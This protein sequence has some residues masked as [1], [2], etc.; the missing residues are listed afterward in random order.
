MK[1]LVELVQ[2]ALDAFMA[3]IVYNRKDG[4][5]ETK[6]S[7]DVD[8]LLVQHDSIH[9]RPRLAQCSYSNSVVQVLQFSI[10]LNS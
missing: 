8:V 10:Y 6:M 5:Q 9:H 1:I 4:L 7:M 2:R 3:V